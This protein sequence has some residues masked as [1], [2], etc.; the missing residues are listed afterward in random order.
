VLDDKN[1]TRENSKGTSIKV[2]F[3][4]PPRLRWANLLA[5]QRPAHL[6]MECDLTHPRLSAG[7]VP[8]LFFLVHGGKES[9]NQLGV[10]GFLVGREAWLGVLAEEA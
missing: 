7:I 2:A 10:S 4:S 5:L 6:T 8:G 1:Y 3:I 9:L